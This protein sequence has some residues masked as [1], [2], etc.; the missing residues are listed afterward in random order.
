MADKAKQAAMTGK[1]E[2]FKTTS[3]FDATAK[4]PSWLE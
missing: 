4:N 2:L 3:H 1:Y